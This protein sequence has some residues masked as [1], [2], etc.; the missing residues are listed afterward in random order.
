MG[1]NKYTLIGLGIAILFY[2]IVRI[3]DIDFFEIF[4]NAMWSMELF[5]IDEF[6]MPLIIIIVFFHIGKVKEQKLYD[7][8]AEKIK[9]YKAMLRANH[10]I[11]NNFLNK[12][13]FYKLKSE[14]ANDYS[15]EINSL[16]DQIIAGTLDQVEALSHLKNINENSITNCYCPKP[17]QNKKANSTAQPDMPLRNN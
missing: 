4:V 5:E 9:V 1:K 7:I 15:E 2:S 16:F 6:I 3:L 8:E 12:I 13:E 10:H 11:L 14:E 17:A